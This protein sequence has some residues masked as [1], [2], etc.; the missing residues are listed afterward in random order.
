MSSLLR[1]TF[2]DPGVIPR[3]SN[4]EAA[5][6]EKQIG[7][8]LIRPVVAIR[9]AVAGT[10][11]VLASI[12]KETWPR[13]L[14]D[15]ACCLSILTATPLAKYSP[16]QTQTLA[17]TYIYICFHFIKFVYVCEWGVKVEGKMRST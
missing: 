9:I 13:S 2:T 3:A 1:T 15:A 5:Y 10:V 14:A 8:L 12:Q 6:I 11:E 4:D 16:T 7:T 17:Y